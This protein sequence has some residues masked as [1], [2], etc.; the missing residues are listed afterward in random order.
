M[1]DASVVREHEG[2]ERGHLVRGEVRGGGVRAR[3]AAR[4]ASPCHAVGVMPRE[5]TSE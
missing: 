2:E 4:N 1:V 5:R 3:P